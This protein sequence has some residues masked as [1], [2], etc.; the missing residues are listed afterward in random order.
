MNPCKIAMIVSGFPRRSE[1]FALQELLAL[2]KKGLLLQIFATKPGDGLPLHPDAQPLLDQVEYLPPG[3]PAQQAERVV[4]RLE[5]QAV[6]GI[7]GYFAHTPAEVAAHV[8]KKLDRPYGF[9]THA[10]DAR[11]VP[12]AI[13]AERAKNT[14]CMI[15]CND[16]V[17]E[18]L[19]KIGGLVTLMPHG[20]D[21]ERFSPSPLPACETLS[22]LSVGRLVEKKGFHLLIRALSRVSFPFHLRII[23]EGP[24]RERLEKDIE[25]HALSDR[26]AL[27]GGM[28]HAELPEAYKNAQIVVV[29][30][31][32][33]RA[34]DRDGL[35]NVVLEAMAS[36]RPV[37]AHNV[38]AIKSAIVSGETGV[39]LDAGNEN[40]LVNVLESLAKDPRL[41]ERLGGNARQRVERDFE[42]GLCTDRFT[43]FLKAVYT[44]ET[45][46][47]SKL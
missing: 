39:L 6:S 8:A 30:S 26:I 7:H 19:K 45:P 46:P 5:G 36:G 38:G 27:C 20:V 23:G 29:P 18:D 3:S 31:I 32:V 17:A 40:A 25:A 15:A 33:N 9:S 44:Q 34:G 37:I 2:Q 4:Q 42:L 24:E 16:D 14:A 28:S 21:L 35:P 22:L 11:K 12:A 10:L 13:L 1:T 47:L 41:C 43:E